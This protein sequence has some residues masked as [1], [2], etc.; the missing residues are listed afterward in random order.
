MDAS[1][2]REVS[3]VLEMQLGGKRLDH[4]IRVIFMRRLLHGN[5]DLKDSRTCFAY[6][7]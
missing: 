1:S 3:D 6:S 5:N 7:P 4:G 2:D